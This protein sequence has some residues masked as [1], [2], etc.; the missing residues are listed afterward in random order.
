MKLGASNLNLLALAIGASSIL[1]ACN[2]T[3]STNGTT[4][5]TNGGTTP[6][7]STGGRKAPTAEGFAV[8]GDK[9]KIG[10][11]ASLSGDQ[12]A[13]GDDQL[14]GCVLAV[15]E[16]NAAGGVNGK[17]IEIVPGDSASKS[18]QAKLAAEK[19][20]GDKV[21][22][23]VGEVASGNTMQIATS[24]FDK[25]V[26][27]IAV[28]ATRTDLTGI[29]S[30]VFRVCY[31]DDFQGPVMAKFAVD[32]LHAKKIAVLTD[33]ALP[34]SKGL[35]ESFSKKVV[36]L[37][38]EIVSNE[39]YVSGKDATDY[40]GVLTGIKKSSPDVL[41]LSGYF[42][43]VGPIA[44]QARAAG[45]TAKFL[46]GDGWDGD[47]ILASG[48]DGIIGGFFCNHYNNLDPA[49]VVQEFLKKW[50][51]KNGGKDPATTM[52]ALG[53]DAMALTIDRLKQASA[54]NSKALIES[55]ENTEG[56]K[57]V[58]G[59]INLKGQNG[60]PSKTA[61]VVE[62]TKKNGSNWQKYAVAYTPDQIK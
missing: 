7:T 39:S 56:F 41:F 28:G 61:I 50:R 48:G 45:I 31:T 36:E 14:A 2:G 20:L 42:T 29:G 23:I 5:P 1:V 62:V 4:E 32:K 12:K 13:W 18:D 37:G 33:N 53:Y 59:V 21:I 27:V 38:G 34:Y 40:A 44:K 9:I 15:E 43:E 49:P 46:G 52:G 17:M 25:G 8:E 10:V 30:H 11:V 6:T 55:L 54:M 57:G 22:A 26:P 19:V 60:N 24:A 16:A 47:A 3:D 51:A 58:S 35:S